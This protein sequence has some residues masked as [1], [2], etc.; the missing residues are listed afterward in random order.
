MWDYTIVKINTCDIDAGNKPAQ[1]IPDVSVSKRLTNLVF[2][3]ATHYI[4]VLK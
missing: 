4:S 2:S 1:I 3:S